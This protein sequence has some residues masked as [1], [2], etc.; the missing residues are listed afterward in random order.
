MAKQSDQSPDQFRKA[1]NRALQ[2]AN[3]EDLKEFI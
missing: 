1:Y 3:L 2:K